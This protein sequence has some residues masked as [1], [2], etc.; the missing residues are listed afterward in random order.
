MSVALKN[1]LTYSPSFGRKLWNKDDAKLLQEALINKQV[2]V[3]DVDSQYDFMHPSKIE[4]KGLYVTNA[5]N[6]IG[7]LSRLTGLVKQFKLPIISTMDSHT[8]HDPEFDLFTAISDGHCIKGTEG[9]QKIPETITSN[10]PQIVSVGQEKNDVPD[11]AE[12][13]KFLQDGKTIIVE[14]NNLDVFKHAVKEKD[15]VVFNNNKK[16]EELFNNL[17][18]LGVKVAI[19]YGVA[20]D[21]CVRKAVEGLKALGIKPIVVEDAIKEVASDDLRNESDPVYKDVTT[22]KK[23]QLVG[24]VTNTK[25]LYYGGTFDPIHNGHLDISEQA[26]KETGAEKIVFLP[27][28]APYHKDDR[29]TTPEQRLEMVQLA[30]KNSSHVEVDDIEYKSK[31]KQSYT[32]DTMKRVIEDEAQKEGYANDQIFSKKNFLIGADEFKTIGSWYRVQDLAKMVKFIVAN[33]P[34]T[35]LKDNTQLR[36]LD[37]KSIEIVPNP[38][39]STLI[40]NNIKTGKSIEGLVPEA[41]EKF[42]YKEQS[43]I[44]IQKK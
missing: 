16:S 43:K 35:S 32:Y 14:K 38:I 31:P 12:L 21:F 7:N 28:Y 27:T 39:S 2:V 40:R 5:E 6:I 41:V 42:I 23:S 3:V 37:Y 44:E 1:I 11:K 13:K 20:T 33:R 30:T 26:R 17:K 8:K 19:V 4:K 34:G 18:E 9:W 10:S 36:D 22:I 15:T 24:E 29:T 25:V